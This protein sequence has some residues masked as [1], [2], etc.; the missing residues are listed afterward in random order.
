MD[1]SLKTFIYNTY[2]F[3]NRFSASSS[4]DNHLHNS[5]FAEFYELESLLSSAMDGAG[6]LLAESRFSRLLRVKSIAT[7]QELGNVLICGPSR[8]GKTLLQDSQLL[9]WKHSAIVNDIKGELFAHTAGLRALYG[10]VF[11]FDPVA[12]VGNR[13]DP[14]QGREKECE[15][16]ASAKH[17]LYDPNDKD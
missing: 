2:L 11:V 7:R 3:Y 13:Y 14:L 12:G 16:Y 15:L 1:K 10:D 17:L 4:H 8:S 6:L 9:T 5:R